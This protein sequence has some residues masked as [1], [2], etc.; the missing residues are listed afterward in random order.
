MDASMRGKLIFK[1]ADL[2]ERDKEYIA[3]LDTVDNGKTMES[4]V[5]DVDQSISTFMY[6]G[7]WADKIHGDTIPTDGNVM[8]YTRMEPVGV[9]GEPDLSLVRHHHPLFRVLRAD[10]PLELSRSHAGLEVG[11]CPG[12]WLHYCPQTCR[13]NS[14]L[15]FVHGKPYQGGW[16]SS[17]RS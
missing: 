16:L 9:V 4:A 1:L 15:S 8:T 7:G 13:A 17:W 3:K 6:F 10:H 12:C 14:A 11:P 5:G 2:M